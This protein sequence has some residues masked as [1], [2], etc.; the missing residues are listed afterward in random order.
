[1]AYWNTKGKNDTPRSKD[2]M[3][4]LLVQG[5]SPAPTLG[6][7]RIHGNGGSPRVNLHLELL[8]LLGP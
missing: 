5:A 4:R 8:A 3:A 1:M 2:Y 6:L 7:V